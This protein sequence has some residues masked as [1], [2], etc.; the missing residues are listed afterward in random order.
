MKVTETLKQQID[1]MSYE[2]MLSMWRFSPVGDAMF[3][4]ESGDY[5]AKVMREKRDAGADHV[6]ASKKIGWSDYA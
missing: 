1:A 2:E 3:E 4:G 6:G 5:F